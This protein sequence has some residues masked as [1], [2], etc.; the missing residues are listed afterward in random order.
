MVKMNEFECAA[1][2][3]EGHVPTKNVTCVY[4]DFDQS[5]VSKSSKWLELME[6]TSISAVLVE[7]Q[8]KLGQHKM[9]MKMFL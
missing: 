7:S 2:E 9:K 8:I 3:P 1:K 6:H 4:S 5:Q